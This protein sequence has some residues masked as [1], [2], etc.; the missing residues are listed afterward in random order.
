MKRYWLFLLVVMLA[1]VLVVPAYAASGYVAGGGQIVEPV[2]DARRSEWKVISF[3]GWTDGD[4]LTGEWEIEFHNVGV[5]AVDG[6]VFHGTDVR[7]TNFYTGN[8]PTCD[9]AMNLT[10]YGEWNQMPGYSVILRA[11][12]DGSP[13]FN[14]TVRVELYDP[15]GIRIYDTH[16]GDE[17]TDESNCVGTARTGLDAGNVTIRLD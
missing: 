13:G 9:A 1:V 11:G 2:V 15:S 17:F 8:T 5:D 16:D 7:Q 3:G 12:D 14:D 10:V 6:T 4:T